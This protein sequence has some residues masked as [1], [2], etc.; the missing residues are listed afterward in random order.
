MIITLVYWIW[1]E[2]ISGLKIHL[3]GLGQ[4]V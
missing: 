1:I 2:E 4:F 3:R